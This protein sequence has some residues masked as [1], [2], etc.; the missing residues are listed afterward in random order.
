[1]LLFAVGENVRF[2]VDLGRIVAVFSRLCDNCL[3]M[4]LNLILDWLAGLLLTRL[5][6]CTP[7]YVR[8]IN[9]VCTS[10]R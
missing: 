10:H 6:G 8:L 5:G 1:M 3:C 4:S 2:V 9:R 7:K